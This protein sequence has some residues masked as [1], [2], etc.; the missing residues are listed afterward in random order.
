MSPS[1][2]TWGSK[3]GVS[4]RRANSAMI[5]LSRARRGS[6]G[7]IESECR[8]AAKRRQRAPSTFAAALNRSA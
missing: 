2:V 6:G 4:R 1:R 7:T 3:K 5:S 8:G